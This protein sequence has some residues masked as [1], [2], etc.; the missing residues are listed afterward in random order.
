M[1]FF[2]YKAIDLEG[3]AI[4]LVRLV[5]GDGDPIQCQLFEAWLHRPEGVVD[6]AA[7]SYAWGGMETPYEIMINGSKK[8]VTENLYL[9]LRYLRSREQDRLLRIDAICIY[10]DR[11]RIKH[12]RNLRLGPLFWEVFGSTHLTC[13]IW[14][15]CSLCC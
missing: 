7:L 2:K 3:P 14:K 8:A 9:A 12:R 15:I 6:Y 11:S 5:K 10:P 1:A 4:R 13:P